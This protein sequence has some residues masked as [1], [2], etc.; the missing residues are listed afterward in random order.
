MANGARRAA[1]DI[2]DAAMPFLR[3]YGRALT[4]HQMSGDTLAAKA[5]RETQPDLNALSAIDIRLQLFANLNDAW[6]ALLGR[7]FSQTAAWRQIGAL[8][9]GSRETLLLRAIEEFSFAQIAQILGV[10]VQLVPDLFETALQEMPYHTGRR[11]LI[12]EDDP[13]VAMDMS[14]CLGDMGCTVTGVARTAS[15]AVL[16]AGSSTPDLIITA[17]TL[18]DRSCGLEAARRISAQHA[19]VSSVFVTP[20]PEKLLTGTKEEPVFIIAKPYLDDQVRSAVSQAFILS[21]R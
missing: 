20:Y 19:R 18:A 8:T 3:R 11:V 13:M 14:S 6:N 17:L 15:E 16:F 10:S 4:G 7:S 2:L 9:P 21:S 5:R 12:I 1:G